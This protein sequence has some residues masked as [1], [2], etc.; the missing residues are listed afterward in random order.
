MAKLSIKKVYNAAE[1]QI[2]RDLRFKS[3]S[4]E[5]KMKELCKLIELS[6]VLGSK[7]S[8][9]RPDGK[10]KIFRQIPMVE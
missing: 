3:L 9:K 4:V 8:N 6:I 5:Q 10:G 2:H 7:Q 1:N